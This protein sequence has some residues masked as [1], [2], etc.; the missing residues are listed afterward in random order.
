[1]IPRK[2]TTAELDVV[3]A[4]LHA[5]HENWSL[6][7]WGYATA[8]DGQAQISADLTRV[9]PEIAAWAATLPPASWPFEAWLTRVGSG[10]T[11]RFVA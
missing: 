10:R 7:R 3:R 5:H 2:W 11:F 8:E 4:H 1:V 6:Y 9:L